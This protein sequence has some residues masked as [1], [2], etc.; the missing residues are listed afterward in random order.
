MK[1][2]NNIPIDFNI[3]NINRSKLKFNK[4]SNREDYCHIGKTK[5]NSTDFCKFNSLTKENY[6]INKNNNNYKN[7]NNKNKFYSRNN[8]K[9]LSSW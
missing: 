1:Y 6:K 5:G 7:K 2:S 9:K 3:N 4:N 8:K